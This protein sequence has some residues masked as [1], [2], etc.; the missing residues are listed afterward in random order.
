MDLIF[1]D[2]FLDFDFRLFRWKLKWLL[3]SPFSTKESVLTDLRKTWKKN[4]M[5]TKN[6]PEIPN[7]NSEL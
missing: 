2:R 6:Y 3:R 4:G 5:G 7:F 1:L